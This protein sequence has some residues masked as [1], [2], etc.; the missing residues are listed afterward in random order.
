MARRK[1]SA[2]FGLD[3]QLASIVLWWPCAKDGTLPLISV[4]EQWKL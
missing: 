3:T 2:T 4:F 1:K